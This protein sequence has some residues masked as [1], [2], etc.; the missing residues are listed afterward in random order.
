LVRLDEQAG[1]QGLRGLKSITILDV[2]EFA[3]KCVYDD[4]K[5]PNMAKCFPNFNTTSN[6]KPWNA[7]RTRMTG[8]GYEC[9]WSLLDDLKL[10]PTPEGFPAPGVPPP[11]PSHD[12]RFRRILAAL[13][14]LRSVV[15]PGQPQGPGLT[16]GFSSILDVLDR[17]ADS[18]GSSHMYRLSRRDKRLLQGPGHKALRKLVEALRDDAD[19]S[20]HRAGLCDSDEC[21]ASQ[22]ARA[23]RAVLAGSGEEGDIPAYYVWISPGARK[24]LKE[25]KEAKKARAK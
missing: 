24:Q 18:L 1:T 19:D 21:L 20:L 17:C 16:D 3:S 14:P 5:W 4:G 15:L 8:F 23:C 10:P 22:T 7:Y 11:P 25:A 13:A 6:D 12:L 9:C 2:C